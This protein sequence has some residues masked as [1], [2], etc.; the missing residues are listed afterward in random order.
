MQHKR[1]VYNKGVKDFCRLR[2]RKSAAKMNQ[3]DCRRRPIAVYATV[4]E[5][6]YWRL[7]LS[8]I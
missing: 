2:A 6:D 8:R 1:K 4:T 7:S 5:S 3:D